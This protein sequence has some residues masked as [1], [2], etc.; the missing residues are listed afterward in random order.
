MAN[1]AA[2]P[3]AVWAAA[4]L[5]VGCDA[6]ASRGTRAAEAEQQPLTSAKAAELDRRLAHYRAH[7]E[8]SIPWEQARAQMRRR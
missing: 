3:F 4:P 2:S 5:R 8:T 6:D 1:K 7:P